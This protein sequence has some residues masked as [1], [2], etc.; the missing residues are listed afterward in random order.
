[1]KKKYNSYNVQTDFGNVNEVYS[2]Y[3]DAFRRYQRT[4]SPKTLYGITEEGKVRVIL[5]K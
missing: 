1:M 2:N 3:L 5:S 4:E